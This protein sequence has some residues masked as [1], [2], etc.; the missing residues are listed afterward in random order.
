MRYAERKYQNA[1]CQ[2]PAW[3]AAGGLMR[4]PICGAQRLPGPYDFVPAAPA[5]AE[6][7]GDI[8]GVD[9]LRL[10]VDG[11]DGDV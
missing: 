10:R 6:R 2:H 1:I 8:R 9:G 11:R 3:V 4:C 7:R 5:P